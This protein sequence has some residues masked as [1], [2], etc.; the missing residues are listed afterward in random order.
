M[1]EYPELEENSGLNPEESFKDLFQEYHDDL[2]EAGS[3]YF[4][5]T[6]DEL[7]FVH[8]VTRSLTKWGPKSYYIKKIFGFI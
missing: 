1:N 7:E 5:N 3:G 2:T 8:E 4:P 6:E